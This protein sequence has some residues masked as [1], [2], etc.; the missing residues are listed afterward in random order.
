MRLFTLSAVAG[1]LLVTGCNNEPSEPYRNS[2]TNL[3]RRVEDALRRMT[4]DE[5]L[6][7]LSGAA[8]MET[9]GVPRL[10]IPPIRMADGPMGVRRWT[11]EGE[12]G[13]KDVPHIKTTAFPAGIALAATWNTALAHQEGQTIAQEALALGRDQMLGPTVNI[14]RTPLW[15]RNF[16]GFGEDPWL[17]GRIAVGY[18]S[19]M[20]GEGVIATVK[21]FAA[22]N[23]E[24]HRNTVNVKVDERA[25]QEIYYP[26]FRAAIEEAGVWSVMS[27][28]NKVNGNWAAENPVLLDEMLKKQWGFKGFVVSDWGSTHSTEATA[29]SGLDVEMPAG[30][31]MPGLI[32]ALQKMPGGNPGFDG[33]YLTRD[34]LKPLVQSGKIQQDTIDDKVRRILRATFG[35]GLFERTRKTG[36]PVDTDEQRAIARTVADQSIVLLKND[37]GVLPVDPGKVRRIA[38]VGPNADVAVTGGGGS[39]EVASSYAIKPLDAIRTRAGTI[40]I[41]YAKDGPA[42][43][44]AAKRADMVIVIAGDDAKVESEMYD[45]KSLDLPPG[46]DELIAN[47]A[48]ANRNTVVVLNA[49]APVAMSKW[50]DGARAVVLA[51]FGGQE[52]GHAIADVLFGD[53]NPSGKLPV[54]FPK[55]LKDTPAY[56][57]Y[58]GANGEVNYSEGI[59]VGYRHYDEKNIEP[60]FPFGHGLSYAKFDYSD[61]RVFPKTPRFSQLVNVTFAV[62]NTG[63]RAGAEVVQVYLHDVK[64]SVPRPPKELKAF[65]R[66]ELK[67]GEAKTIELQLEPRTMSFYDPQMKGWA[68]E[69]GEFEVFIGSSSRDI[70]LKDKF[71]L[72]E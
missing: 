49:G 13:E 69:P 2:K 32:A 61:L 59:F 34:K 7:M 33:G 54:T 53:V 36:G 68:T 20:Q 6:D 62:K 38:V 8:W 71:E 22:N 41:D 45:R 55:E 5:K 42:A 16:E 72:F 64:S 21:H 9:K 51:W 15:G 11:W 23:Q 58:P 25:L 19:G 35:I 44:D 60:L 30:S 29:N 65:T 4:E 56:G 10:G 50:L 28:Y 40:A 27:A 48:R 67:P 46:Q 26:A 17:A 31:T 63:A 1:V 37:A 43:I 39:S 52:G 12:P 18:I 47:V 14:N 24:D 66:V 3:D 57:N 70:R